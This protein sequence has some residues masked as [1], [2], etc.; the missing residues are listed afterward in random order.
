[1]KPIHQKPKYLNQHLL[2]VK[3]T[4]NKLSKAVLLKRFRSSDDCSLP[5]GTTSPYDVSETNSTNIQ[6][7]SSTVSLDVT[8]GKEP[9]RYTN[10]HVTCET[11]NKKDSFIQTKPENDEK[12]KSTTITDF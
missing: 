11:K 12:C 4:N 6:P 8:K 3:G 7:A 5:E 2:P 1:M 10:Y 9:F